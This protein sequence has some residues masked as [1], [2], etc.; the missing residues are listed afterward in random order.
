MYAMH[1]IGIDC[2]DQATWDHWFGD[3]RVAS[4][5]NKIRCGLIAD[6]IFSLTSTQKLK[7]MMEIPD[8]LY[9]VIKGVGHLPVQEK[10]DEVLAILQDFLCNFSGGLVCM[11]RSP[12][13]RE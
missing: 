8:E 9:H 6:G 13:R 11:D 3:S 1:T 4:L 10:G 5:R 12:I 2:S 7:E